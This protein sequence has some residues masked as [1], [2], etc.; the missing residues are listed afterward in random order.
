MEQTQK[1]I[2]K[3]YT[4]QESYDE[5]A[6]AVENQLPAIADKIDNIK[7]PEIDTTELAKQGENQEAT[8]S[9]ILEEVQN[10]LTPLEAVLTELNNGKQEMVDALNNK[11]VEASQNESLST[12]AGK[13][14]QISQEVVEFTAEDYSNAVSINGAI[15]D[16]VKVGVEDK[17]TYAAKVVAEFYKESDTIELSGADAYATSDGAFY[18]ANTMHTWD[19][20]D[21]E[22][23]N[24]YVIYYYVN[25]NVDFFAMIP[26]QNLWVS[27]INNI[28]I[29][30]ANHIAK[31]YGEYNDIQL[32]EGI[33]NNY[34]RSLCVNLKEHA[35]DYV[36]LDN[37]GT[38]TLEELVV[39][40][41]SISSP[42]IAC[43]PNQ[44]VQT[45][46]F[47]K[48]K[49]INF[50]TLEVI[51]ENTCAIHTNKYCYGIVE[52]ISAPKLK[53]IM[54][55]SYLTNSFNGNGY[56]SKPF[57]N[58]TELDFPSLEYIG[59]NACLLNKGYMFPPLCTTI[60]LPNL[61]TLDG[62]IAMAGHLSLATND[63]YVSAGSLYSINAPNLVSCN[64]TIFSSDSSNISSKAVKDII[65]GALHTNLNLM[66]WDPKT[67]LSNVDEARNIINN[68]RAHIYERV[69]DRT[70]QSALTVTFGFTSMLNTY[71]NG[72]SEQNAEIIAMWTAL[73]EDF[74]NNKNWNVA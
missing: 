70:G 27:G 24:R 68:I 1:Q 34:G 21:S 44:K 7:L 49:H 71:S 62:S 6:N 45:S 59:V 54:A 61:T 38:S 16:I 67:Y 2:E 48:L 10:K 50:P 18:E 28:V 46:H 63:G 36:I 14:N 42:I 47:T 4:L 40:V 19:D 25:H 66:M 5:L 22:K 29:P 52:R 65:V 53:K 30:V 32:K 72:T 74:T 35:S 23:L 41:K 20:A 39:G 15:W 58:I 56:Y 26:Y 12:L 9:K 17:R 57:L 13:V 43:S 11:G 55:G 51:E 8:N 37:T 60:N 73:K 64:G 69:S 31:I 3:L 33:E